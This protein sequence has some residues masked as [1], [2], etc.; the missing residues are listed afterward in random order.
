MKK[1]NLKNFSGNE[2]Q[3]IHHIKGGGTTT[4]KNLGDQNWR[5][6][7]TKEPGQNGGTV[8]SYWEYGKSQETGN[9][10]VD[11]NLSDTGD[12]PEVDYIMIS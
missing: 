1:F 3:N 4:W 11:I 8:F 6:Q 12:I 7:D 10:R 5:G 2:I 9:H